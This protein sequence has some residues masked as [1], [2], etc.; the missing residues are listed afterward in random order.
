LVG[1][2][3]L[4][5]VEPEGPGDAVAGKAYDQGDFYFNLKDPLADPLRSD[6]RFQDL[7]RRL[8]TALE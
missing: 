6:P 1:L 8:N 4:R 7:Q 3:G 2:P 5:R